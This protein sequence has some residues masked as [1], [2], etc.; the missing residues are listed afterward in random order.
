M[1]KLILCCNIY[2]EIRR[3]TGR[4]GNELFILFTDNAENWSAFL[5]G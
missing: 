4:A 1:Q 5:Q 3:Q 2:A